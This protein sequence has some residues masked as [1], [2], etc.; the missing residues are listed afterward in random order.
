[1]YSGQSEE[2][3]ELLTAVPLSRVGGLPYVFGYLSAFA[4]RADDSGLVMARL[5]DCSPWWSGWEN[6]LERGK[7]GDLYF[8]LGGLHLHDINSGEIASSELVARVSGRWCP[9]AASSAQQSY[10]RPSFVPAGIGLDASWG[11]RSIED[12][13]PATVIVG[14]DG[15]G[16]T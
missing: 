9:P 16:N 8:P 7:D 13:P 1:M 10:V 3:Y 15:H 2:G 6:E 14:L 4:F 11:Q 5:H 12:P